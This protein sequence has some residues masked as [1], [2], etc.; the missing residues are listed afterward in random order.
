MGSGYPKLSNELPL[1]SQ[2]RAVETQI[3]EHLKKNNFL[4][5]HRV[6]RIKMGKGRI[7]Y[8]SKLTGKA[9][10]WVF[11]NIL[12]PVLLLARLLSK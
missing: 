6:L 2:E 12:T 1:R 9:L 10:V 7:S 5:Y 11:K 4:E 3:I 8:Y